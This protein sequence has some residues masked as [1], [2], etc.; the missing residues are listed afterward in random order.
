MGRQLD[1]GRA[2]FC[3]LYFEK[4]QSTVIKMCLDSSLCFALYQL[5]G[6]KFSHLQNR[7]HDDTYLA[8]LCR[9]SECLQSASMWE[10]LC[11]Q[12]S[13][14][15]LC[16]VEAPSTPTFPCRRRERPAGVKA[17]GGSGEA[18]ETA[19]ADGSAFA[20]SPEGPPVMPGCSVDRRKPPK[21]LYS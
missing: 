9:M 21:K 6:L 12:K 18:E 10:V 19:R 11:V 13:L 14:L 7:G 8:R 5:G 17:W 1:Y 2:L 20:R 16:E 15:L 4:Q 3:L